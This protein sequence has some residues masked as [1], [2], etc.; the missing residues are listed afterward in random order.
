MAQRT[1]HLLDD[2]ATVRDWLVAGGWSEPVAELAELLEPDGDPWGENGR[3]VLTNGPDVTLLKRRL[4]ELCPLWTDQSLPEVV[5]GGP[6]AYRGPTG[7]DHE[8]TWRRVHV[9]GDGL[10][11]WSEFCFTPAY[12]VALSGTV[13]E[14]D[15]AEWRLLRLASTGPCLLYVNGECVL[16]TGMVSYMEP[17]EHEVRVWLPSGESSVVVSSWQV[18]FRECRQVVRLRVGGLPVRVVVPSPG[19]DEERAALAEQLLD[20]VGTPRWGMTEPRLELTGPDGVPLRVRVGDVERRVRLDDGRATVSLE[21]TPA[22]EGPGSASMLGTG[23]LTAR[24]WLDDDSS[25][26]FRDLGVAVLGPRYR[27]EPEGD[28]ATW[29][30]EVL[31]HAADGQN[32][33]AA[34]LAA[35]TRD[36]AHAPRADRLE[37]A[38]G[39]LAN[40]ADCS[41]FEVLGLLHLWHRVP[42]ASWSTEPA[43]TRAAVREALLGMKY[44]ID[45]PGLDAMCY[46]T[47]NHQLVWHT[48]EYLAGEA[49]A[50]ET[51]ANT[52][53]TGRRHAEHGAALAREWLTARLAGGFSEFDS[54]AYLAI[55]VLALVSLVEFGA[56]GELVELAAGL[57]DKTLFTLATNSW[58]GAHVSAHGRSYVR[59]QR[60]ARFE[61]TA[62][63]MWLCWGV[64]ALNDATLPATALATAR[65]YVL[66]DAVRAAGRLSGEWFGRQRYRGT[67]RAEHDLLSR[68]YSSDLAVYRTPHAMLS[69]A[70]DYRRGLPGLQ[71]LIWTA[72]LG[73]ETQVYVTHA[74]NDAVH[75]SA[76]PNAWAGNR[77]LPR[78]R[79]HRD[80]VLALYRIPTDDPAGYTHAW[81][82]LSTMD[83]WVRSGTWLAGRRGAGYVALSTQDGARVLAAGSTAGQELRANGPGLAWVCVV[84]DADRDGGF[85]EFVAALGEPGYGDG[86]VSYRTRHGVELALDWTGP[87]T[88]DGR[89]A[90]LDALGDERPHLDNPLVRIPFGAERMELDG[91]VID[92]RRGRP[93]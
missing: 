17:I 19:A 27:G 86:T 20:A 93:V 44:W 52:G 72:A 68:P 31:A 61:E 74:P 51:F 26:V 78:A 15:Q 43:D 63:I 39:M 9:P 73:P 21:R 91:H 84:G 34:E 5:E 75:S 89:P 48:A 18:G 46:F 7:A 25:P 70:E 6:V 80:T 28:P 47:E 24:V 40:R 13:F 79:Q 76:R 60:S 4:Y 12:R 45:Q 37:H 22:E 36:P 54:N 64:G 82:P 30:E 1:V 67:Y 35:A 85:A 83:E 62:P 55:D 92:L 49:F 81:F 2:N 57:L 33:C 3:W 42:E 69:C 8:D 58:R 16:A 29:R 32:G 53:W 88:V 50:D 65:R 66:P 23:E 59:T 14:V 77:I 10:V 90:D 11:D 56:D 41:D 38:L 87:F 71:E